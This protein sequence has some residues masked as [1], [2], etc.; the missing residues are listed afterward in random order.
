MISAT[1][2]LYMSK[3]RPLASTA[4]DGTFQL[5]LLAM[6][7]IGPHKVEPWHLTWS[8]PEAKEFWLA[9]QHELKPGQPLHF[10]ATGVQSFAR[11][12]WAPETHARVQSCALAPHRVMAG[13]ALPPIDQPTRQLQS[14]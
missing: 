1:G 9:H 4:A 6:D 13:T 14:H 2:T 8:G 5:T 11:K 12:G 7:R 3:T 10:C